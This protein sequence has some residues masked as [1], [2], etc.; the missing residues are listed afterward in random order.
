LPPCTLGSGCLKI[1]NQNGATAPAPPPSSDTNDDWR[2]EAALDTE[3]LSA[4]CPNCKILLVQ[5]NSNRNA[6]LDAGVNAAVAAGAVAVGNSYSAEEEN[7]SDG[8]YG[9]SGHAITASAGNE[10]TGARE[11]CS[12]SGVVCVGGT[13]LSVSSRGW[14]ERAWGS[15][16]SG[17]SAYVAKPQWQHAKGC[18]TRSEV[19]VSAVADPNTGVA[20]YES[21]G[22]GWQ[23][24]G[25]TSVAAQIV[26]AAFALGPSSAL[27]N[28]PQWIWRHGGSSAY[29]DVTSGSNGECTAPFICHARPGY[30][31]PTGWGT[32]ARIV[33]F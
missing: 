31:G 26:A 30:D 9:H 14:S 6:D 23:Q 1:V 10:G 27:T 22:G 2:P 19:D 32:P 7:A 18:A 8:A 20:F 5:T 24:A 11:P 25:G 28:A 3:M 33:G 29:R 13:S 16:G 4:I 12:Y 21:A 17:C 15:T